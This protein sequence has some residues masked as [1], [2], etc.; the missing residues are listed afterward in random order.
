MAAVGFAPGTVL[1]DTYRLVRRVGS[2][3]VGEV[4][5]AAHK[6]LPG[7]FAVKVLF[8]DASEVANAGEALARCRRDAEAASA[9]RHPHI[10]R[11]VDWNHAPD[12][13]PYVV[14][15]LLEGHDLASELAGGNA[16]PLG[17]AALIV[18]QVASALAAAHEK[19]VVHGDLKPANVFVKEVAASG[20]PFAKVLD[21]GMAQ[22]KGVGALTQKDAPAFLAPEQAGGRSEDVDE[23]ADQFAL[24]A[25][26]YQM[27]S[28][29]VP[30]DA[31]NQPPIGQIGP[32]SVQELDEVLRKALAPEREARYASLAHFARAV[33]RAA[34]SIEDR[35]PPPE[36]PE[37]FDG[38]DTHAMTEVSAPS[39]P[40]TFDAE[41]TRPDSD[42]LGG[43][44][45][46]DEDR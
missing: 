43:R 40:E 34:R 35:T 9:L 3:G 1:Q 29:R 46:D 14:T 36:M 4:Y 42:I 33:D 32:V 26:L 44:R 13:R 6:R 11:V 41:P 45:G 25:M 2:G 8:A 38:G 19:G 30:L 22:V 37:E 28:G 27:A 24:A 17:R 10:V 20:K 39:L 16:I 21:F 15:E 18:E 7:R 23:R 31:P 5:E 12:G